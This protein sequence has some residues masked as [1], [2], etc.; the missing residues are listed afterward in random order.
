[1][2]TN[3]AGYAGKW[4]SLGGREKGREEEREGER[5]ERRREER[6]LNI[7]PRRH[8]HQRN[9]NSLNRQKI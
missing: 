9:I 2:L 6:I 1:M 5:E 4:P 3:I 8:S 7:T